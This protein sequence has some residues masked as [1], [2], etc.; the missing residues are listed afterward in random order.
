MSRINPI[1]I[2]GAD[3][4]TKTLLDNVN[5][6]L[7]V[8]PNFMRTLAH[9]PA[10]LEAYLAFGKALG[11]GSLSAA[12]REQIALTVASANSCEYCTA[13]HTALGAKFGL[14]A[15][16]MKRNLRATAR[17]PKVEAALK[18]ALALV[19]QQG[20]VTDEELQGVR[21]AGYGD[22]EIN[23]IIAA[24]A[25]TIFSTYFNHVAGTDVDFPLVAAGEPATA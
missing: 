19:R 2:A 20:W 5:K 4:K 3:G 9:S 8:T 7:G 14:E 24:T 6:A 10:A 23:E 13:A 18:F 1:E 17:D 22:G 21:E 12:L 11:G 25:I 15:E 16:E